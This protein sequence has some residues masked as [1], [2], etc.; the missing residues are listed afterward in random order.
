LDRLDRS[1]WFDP[2]LD[3]RGDRCNRG[4]SLG[5][6]PAGRSNTG[7]LDRLSSRRPLLFGGSGVTRRKKEGK[8]DT[9]AGVSV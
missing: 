9:G 4:D 6:D 5:L 2:W 3:G 1:D 7:E 8:L